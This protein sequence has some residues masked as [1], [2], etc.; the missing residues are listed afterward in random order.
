VGR[1]FQF[2]LRAK[3]INVLGWIAVLALS[4]VVGNSQIRPETY[5]ITDNVNLVLLDVSVKGSQGRYVRGLTQANFTVAEDGHRRDI[6]QF[7]NVDVPVTI[8]LVV[9]DSGSMRL[10]RPQVVMAGLSF[11]KESNRRDQFFVVNFNDR[12]VFGLPPAIAFTDQLQQL[13]SALYLGRPIGQTALYDAVAAALHHLELSQREKRT[14]IVVSDGG[15]NAS[16]A[17]L[18]DILNLAQASRATI[19]TVGLLDPFDQ[20]LNPKV[21]RKLA[22]VTGGEFFKPTTPA[23][24]QL[25]FQEICRDIRSRYSIGYIPDIEKDNKHFVHKVKVTA[26]DNAGHK[27]SVLTRTSYTMALTEQISA[28][29][30]NAEPRR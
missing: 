2:M 6:T 1:A 23:Q 10:T 19:Y 24:V 7:A 13:R 30:Q 26:R 21:L 20:D 12:V 17:N 25:T 14:L 3:R 27:L 29:E 28:R 22:S 8:G 4:T 15:D 11:A 18:P 16:Q 5:T 9:D